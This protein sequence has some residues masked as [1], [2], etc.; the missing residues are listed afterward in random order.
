MIDELEIHNQFRESI[1]RFESHDPHLKKLN[2]VKFVYESKLLEEENFLIPGI[3]LISGGRQIGKT[4]FLKQLILKW[5]RDKTFLPENLYFITGE[6]IDTHHV[7]RR[8]ITTFHKPE[9]RQVLFIDEVNYIP[10]WDKSVKY[11][12]DAGMTENMSIILTGSDNRIIKTSMKRFAGRRGMADPVDFEFFP[13]NFLEAVSLLQPE[14]R[15][16]YEAISEASFEG[17]AGLFQKHYQH[18]SGLFA[19]YCI[20][21]GFLPAIN[22]FYSLSDIPK[23]VFTIYIHWII[24][25]F[26]KYNKSENYLHE[27]LRGI[28]KTYG[29]QVSWTALAKNLSIEHHKTVSDYCHILQSMNVLHVIEAVLEDKLTAAP[30]KN[31]KLHF[32]DPFIYHAVSSYVDD[33]DFT[34]I[35]EDARTAEFVSSLVESV[36]ISHCKR[37]FP[38]YYISG[39]KGEVDIALVNNKKLLP[40]EVKWT[41]QIRPEELK[42]IS[43]YDNGLILTKSQNIRTIGNNT[44]VPLL[45]FLLQISS[46]NIGL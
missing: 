25:D 44:A 4:T 20:H 14:N 22:A 5:L 15:K 3:Y 21:G 38:T 45:Q 18:L 12:A 36:C 40:V 16:S 8:I 37:L 6:L 42:Q 33:A 35:T 32:Q 9:Q 1:T 41:S 10:D 39:R 7:L 11:I 27:L 46:G 2:S 31:K 17:G 23:A 43:L 26:L 29:S 24:G 13:L 34:A 28:Q 30:K 19:N